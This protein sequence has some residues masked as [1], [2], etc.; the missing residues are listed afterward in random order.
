SATS[1]SESAPRRVSLSNMPESL[2]ERLSNMGF[3]WAP[4]QAPFGGGSPRRPKQNAPGSATR[5]RTWAGRPQGTAGFDLGIS[6][7]IGRFLGGGRAEVN[8][9]RRGTRHASG[10]GEAFLGLHALA[11][12]RVE[13]DRNAEPAQMSI[14]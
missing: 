3:S 8:V 9:K 6:D 14:D 11:I 5:R 10:G 12:G 1:A 7:E 2:S 13:D 4:F